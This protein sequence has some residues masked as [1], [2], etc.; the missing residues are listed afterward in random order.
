MPC[1]TVGDE[2]DE[3]LRHHTATIRS[4][5]S[6]YTIAPV[7]GA[8]TPKNGRRTLVLS[9]HRALARLD[10]PDLTTVVSGNGPF[11][12]AMKALEQ[13]LRAVSA[14]RRTLRAG[15]GFASHIRN[16]LLDDGDRD[17][18]DELRRIRN[19]IAHQDGVHVSTDFARDVILRL[20][21]MAAALDGH[22]I[23]AATVMIP[24]PATVRPDDPIAKAQGV[25]L[26]HDYS[27]LPVCE[28]DETLV[29]LVTDQSLLRRLRR[30]G[31]G[32]NPRQVL[33][34]EALAEH[35]MTTVSP[36]AP[37]T[38]VSREIQR[39]P[40]LR[41]ALVVDDRRVLG[42]ITHADLLRFQPS[43]LGIPE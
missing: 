21:P 12:D 1:R 32:T 4:A 11:L 15:D 13:C 29:G 27:Q 24:A 30:R 40:R 39:D 19:A 3:N 5:I 33:V 14:S 10:T 8:P 43:W 16:A 25:M 18:L 17:W 35:A 26:S 38:E 36:D 31:A 41:A 20:R 34:I 2:G 9:L 42:I 23:V 7:T 6:L 22:E 28:L 37:V